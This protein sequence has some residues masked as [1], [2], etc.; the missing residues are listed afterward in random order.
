MLV[1]LLLG[2][3]EHTVSSLPAFLALGRSSPA[4][5]RA[6]PQAAFVGPTALLSRPF[7]ATGAVC[8]GGFGLG[9]GGGPCVAAPPLVGPHGGLGIGSAPRAAARLVEVCMSG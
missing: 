9:V 5:G 7:Q 4:G 1:V 2:F 3:V 6:L 8:H